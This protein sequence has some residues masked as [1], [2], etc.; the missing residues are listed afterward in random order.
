MLNH[1][2]LVGAKPAIRHEALRDHED[3]A[4]HAIYDELK[5]TGEKLEHKCFF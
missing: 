2:A 5:A 3:K 1:L 4:F